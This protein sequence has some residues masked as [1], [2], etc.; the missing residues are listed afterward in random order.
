MLSFNFILGAIYMPSHPHTIL[1]PIDL[2]HTIRSDWQLLVYGC[3]PSTRTC[4]HSMSSISIYSQNITLGLA[5]SGGHFF[6]KHVTFSYQNDRLCAIVMPASMQLLI[7]N[8]SSIKKWQI[9]MVLKRKRK[10]TY[11]I[12]GTAWTEL[13][14]CKFL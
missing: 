1:R 11:T 7:L 6:S 3:V 9:E 12:S 5:Y 13:K 10:G 14:L 8:I 4:L 2:Q